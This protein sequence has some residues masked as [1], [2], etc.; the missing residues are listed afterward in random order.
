MLGVSEEK[1]DEE[2]VLEIRRA[3]WKKKLEEP[4]RKML[5]LKHGKQRSND[6][7]ESEVCQLEYWGGANSIKVYPQIANKRLIYNFK[8]TLNGLLSF[9]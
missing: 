3:K 6:Q 9:Y 5:K 1:V 7:S 4:S 2:K 8:C